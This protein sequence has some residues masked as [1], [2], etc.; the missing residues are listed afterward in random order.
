MNSLFKETRFRAMLRQ[1]FRL[2]LRCL[3]ESLLK[4]LC[5]LLMVLLSGTFQERLIRCVYHEGVFKKVCGLR[6]QS[7]LIDEFSLD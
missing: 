5:N 6:W 4:N 3:R 2:R 1:S 7:S